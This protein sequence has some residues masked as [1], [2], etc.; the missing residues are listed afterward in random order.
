MAKVNAKEVAKLRKI[1]GAG[2]MDCK[3]ALEQSEGDFEKAQEIIR[4]KGLSIA[5]R[6]SDRE[7][8]EG[9]VIAKTTSDKKQGI[10]ISLNCETDFVAKNDGFVALAHKIAD[11]VLEKQPENLDALLETNIE[12][13]S[14]KEL[15]VEQTGV[16]GEKLEL[17]YYDKI[18]AERVDAYIHMGNK[19]ASLVG[20]NKDID[21]E[22]GHEVVMQVAAMNPVA[23]NKDEVPE[24]VMESELEIGRKQARNEGKPEELVDKI[25]HGKLNKFFK[26]NTLLSQAYVKDNK[27][28]VQQFLNEVDKDLTV[29]GFKRYSLG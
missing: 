20:L 27:K 19:I 11:L 29:T 9:A 24:S 7:A 3:K 22:A 1:T 21:T 16:T 28:S 13:K 10:I 14:V 8:T 12:G 6:R 17:K 15:V 5:N 4:E 23:L 25:A 26:E 2:M 18:C